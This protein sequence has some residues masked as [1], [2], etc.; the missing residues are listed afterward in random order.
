MTKVKFEREISKRDQEIVSLKTRLQLTKVNL[1]LTQDVVRAIQEQLATLSTP[2]IPSGKDN[3]TEGEKRT[4]EKAPATAEGK[5]KEIVI[6]RESSF[7][8]ILEEGEIDE[9][10][11]LEFVEGVFT[12]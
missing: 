3:T 8:H 11:V 2:P 10:Y 6:E 12:T 5:G 1:S 9:P 7:S 4:Q